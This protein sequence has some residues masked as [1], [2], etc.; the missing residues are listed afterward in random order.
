MVSLVQYKPIDLDINL[1]NMMNSV[2][3]ILILF[4]THSRLDS[5]TENRQLWNIFVHEQIPP[6]IFRSS[7]VVA[8]YVSNTFQFINVICD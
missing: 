7:D 8:Q 6:K 4:Y 3:P 5:T 2:T 1:S